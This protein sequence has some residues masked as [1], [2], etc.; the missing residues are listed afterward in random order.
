[1]GLAWAGAGGGAL[2]GAWQTLVVGGPLGEGDRSAKWIVA[3]ALGGAAYLACDA[4]APLSLVSALTGDPPTVLTSPTGEELARLH[5]LPH[6]AY[7][8]VT[9]TALIALLPG[10]GRTAERAR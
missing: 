1:M 6:L 10:R 5:V 2:L 4:A 8:A 3:S 9:A 7:G